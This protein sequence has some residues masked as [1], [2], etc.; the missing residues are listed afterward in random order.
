MVAEHS[1][2][3]SSRVDHRPVGAGVLEGLQLKLLGGNR[4]A[5]PVTGESSPWLSGSSGG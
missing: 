1:G 2:C 4:A 5:V 3:G